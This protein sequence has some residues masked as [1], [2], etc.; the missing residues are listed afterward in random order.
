MTNQE[1]LTTILG[2]F[3]VTEQQIVIILLENDIDPNGTV[4]GSAD[5]KAL[6]MGVYRQLPLMLAGMQDVSE[7]GYSIK[8]NLDGIKL[9]YSALANELGQ[10]DLLSPAPTV[11]GIKPW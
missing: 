7:G 4:S 11:T 3:G 1:Y 10:P 8:W 2:T 6:K 5:M 9:W